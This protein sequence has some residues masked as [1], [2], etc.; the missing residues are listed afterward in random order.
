M[1]HISNRKSVVAKHP[2]LQL[3]KYQAVLPDLSVNKRAV[4]KACLGCSD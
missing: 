3:K 2:V 4:D 1:P